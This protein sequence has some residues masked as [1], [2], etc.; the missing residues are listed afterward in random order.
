MRL[1]DWLGGGQA[2]SVAEGEIKEL[3]DQFYVTL[4]AYFA[5][6]QALDGKLAPEAL[7]RLKDL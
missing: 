5:K 1:R 4:R 7:Q 2:N 3:T 6:I